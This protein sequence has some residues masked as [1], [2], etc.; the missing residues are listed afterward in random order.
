MPTTAAC[1][2]P[3]G[4]T[5]CTAGT[6]GPHEL[7]QLVACH[8]SASSTNRILVASHVVRAHLPETVELET[9]PLVQLSQLRP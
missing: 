9:E 1:G 8:R 2:A 6:F 3:P 5:D 7:K 4:E